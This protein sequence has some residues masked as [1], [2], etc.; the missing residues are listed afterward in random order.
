M[1]KAL[2]SLVL[3]AGFLA[4]Q[5]AMLPAQGMA[6]ADA[7]G[8]TRH[9]IMRPDPETRRLWIDRY[10]RAP[11]A[12]IDRAIL[13]SLG[14]ADLLPFL[15]Y[16]PSARD[17]GSCGNCWAWAGTGVM[18]IALN[19][20]KEIRDRLSVQY[21]NS[22]GYSVIGKQCCEGGWLYDVADFYGAT[23]RAIPWSNTNAHWQDG[24]ASCDTSCASIALAPAY[25]IVS[26]QEETIETQ[27]VG[28]AQA[29][30]NIKN[31][32]DQNRAVWFAFFICNTTDWIVFFDFW[33]TQAE[34]VL[35]DFDYSCDKEWTSGGGGHA[36]LCVGYNDEDPVNR[37]WVMLNSWGTTAGRPNGLFRV[38]MDIDYDCADTSSD[39]NL[40]WQTLDVSFGDAPTPVPTATPTPTPTRCPTRTHLMRAPRRLIRTRRRAAAATSRTSA[41]TSSTTAST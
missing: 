19:V 7:A 22:C 39:Y 11:R 15:E 16:T 21:I 10:D 34:S 31:V 28:Q 30:A 36:V 14:S 2:V 33:N 13:S 23:E 20:E 29:I 35:F 8:E 12:R 32:L 1:K 4:A 27:G 26:I 18:E 9:P 38:S 37:Y 6:S 25:G 3:A 17:Q 24:D 41:R 5:C 40:Y